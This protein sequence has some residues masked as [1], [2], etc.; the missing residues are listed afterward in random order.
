VPSTTE[1]QDR[2]WRV[3]QGL[4]W[5]AVADMIG[6]AVAYVAGNVFASNILGIPTLLIIGAF[7]LVGR[8][9]QKM[10]PPFDAVRGTGPGRRVAKARLA[11]FR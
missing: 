4:A 9:L 1:K 2:L 5:L 7:L 11:C 10:G 8:A 3:M 6:T